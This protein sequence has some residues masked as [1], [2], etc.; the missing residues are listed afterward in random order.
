MLIIIIF[1]HLPR[2]IPMPMQPPPPTH[3]LST[4]RHM[5]PQAATYHQPPPQHTHTH[6]QPAR[7]QQVCQGIGFLGSS[8]ILYGGFWLKEKKLNLIKK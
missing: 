3:V 5:I 8:N 2:G 7:S 6:A 1:I 4:T